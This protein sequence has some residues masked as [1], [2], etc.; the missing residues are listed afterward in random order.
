[1]GS[2]RGRN[3]RR[4]AGN[5]YIKLDLALFQSLPKADTRCVSAAKGCWPPV[6]VVPIPGALSAFSSLSPTSPL[7]PLYEEGAGTSPSDCTIYKENPP[8]FLN[9]LIVYCIGPIN[10]GEEGISTHIS[11][12]ASAFCPQSP[13]LQEMDLTKHLLTCSVLGFRYRQSLAK[14]DVLCNWYTTET[15][16]G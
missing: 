8:T 10:N 13:R 15:K 4:S 16:A 3:V 1:M 9:D 6:P 5:V 14:Q 11:L 12:K 2:P 7:T